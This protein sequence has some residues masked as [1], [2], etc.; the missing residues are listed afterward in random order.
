MGCVLQS[1][2]TDA[3]FNSPVEEKETH[4]LCIHRLMKKF[5]ALSCLLARLIMVAN[6]ASA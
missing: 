6:K 4:T 1:K 3:T 5:E 2:Q